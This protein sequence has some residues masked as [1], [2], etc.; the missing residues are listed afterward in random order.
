MGPRPGPCWSRTS[1]SRPTAGTGRPMPRPSAGPCSFPPPGGCGSP[2]GPE[3]GTV[4]VKDIFQRPLRRPGVP[5]ARGRHPVLHCRR[6][7][8][9]ALS[10]GSPTAPGP[11]LCWSRTSSRA[12][13]VTTTSTTTAPRRL[14]PRRRQAFLHRL[15][16][17]PRAG[18]CRGRSTAP[19]PAPSWSRTQSRS[20]TNRTS[21]GPKSWSPGAERSSSTVAA[22]GSLT[23]LPSTALSDLT[24]PAA[25]AAPLAAVGDEVFFSERDRGRRARS[26]GSRTGPA[27]GRS[28]SR[29]PYGPGRKSS[30]NLY[31]VTA[32]GEG[33][34][35]RAADGIHGAEPWAS[36]GTEKGTVMVQGRSGLRVT[37]ARAPRRS[38]RSGGRSSSPPT[39]GSTAGSCGS[40]TAP[41]AARSWSRTS[42]RGQQLTAHRELRALSQHGCGGSAAVLHRG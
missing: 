30:A 26:R 28:W 33:V 40:R 42:T 11:A 13:R 6:R 34:F 3:T 2:T 9:R 17:S 32:A 7:R 38:R 41:R 39:T 35:F 36:D 25:E 27:G 5:H 16:R 12:P 4:L 14:T 20:T 8:A 19:R 1:R 21:M 23:A 22:C 31:N 10:C 18:S 29:R 24:D 37:R 15:R